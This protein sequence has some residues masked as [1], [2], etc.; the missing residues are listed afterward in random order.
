MPHEPLGT[1]EK[2]AAPVKPERDLDTEMMHG[3]LAFVAPAMLAFLLAVW[4][5]IAFSD[6][7]RM[8]VLVMNTVLGLVPAVVAGIYA[9][10]KMGLAGACGV[11]ASAL[12]TSIFLYLRMQQIELSRGVEEM[13][14]VEYPPQF[15][16]LLPLGWSLLFIVLALLC[17]RRDELPD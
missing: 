3:C 4:P 14:S 7:Y 5:H 13:P 1:D 10:R 2:L 9:A 15:A 12:A 17:L 6:V 11:V 8:Q 16:W